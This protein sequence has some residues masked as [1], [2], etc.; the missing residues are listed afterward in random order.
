MDLFTHIKQEI[1]KKFPRLDY[2]IWLA[3]IRLLQYHDSEK[4]LELSTSSLFKKEK[5]EEKYLKLIFAIAQGY[6]EN[7][8]R[9]EITY[10]KNEKSTATIPS[11]PSSAVKNSD[12]LKKKPY[13]R[14][15]NNIL[16]ENNFRNYVVYEENQLAFDFARKVINKIGYIN[17]LFIYGKIGVGKTHLIQAIYQEIEEKFPFYSLKYINPNDFVSE[18]TAALKVKQDRQFRINYRS[19]DILFIDDIQFF[20]GK[21]KSTQEFFDIFNAIFTP[22]KQ[23]IFC[24]DREPHDLGKIDERLKSRLASSV[25]LELQSPSLKSKC[26]LIEFFNQ[27]LNLYLD[28]K[29]VE[30]LGEYLASDVRKI[31]GAMKSLLFFKEIYNKKIDVDFCLNNLKHLTKEKTEKRLTPEEI[32]TRLAKV[33]NV[34]L[35]E[36]KSTK[37]NKK[38]TQIRKIAM[39]ALRKNTRKSFKEIGDYLGNKTAAAVLYSVNDIEKKIS[40]DVT[41]NNILKKIIKD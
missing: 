37:Q 14:K 6:I 35:A 21:E 25:I 23:M 2:Q 12:G 29:V 33:T 41:I 5:I 7:L 19:L 28:K 17:P 24:S 3:D 26:Q 40:S 16:K 22:D 1:Q 30:F 11:L 36:I 9:V 39:Y 15:K 31:K 38:I 34:S 20:I 10:V 18:Y 4:T 32:I 27:K 13:L 8:K